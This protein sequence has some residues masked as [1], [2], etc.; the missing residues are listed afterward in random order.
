MGI[1]LDVF[2]VL[3]CFDNLFDVL[4]LES[5]LILGFFKLTRGVNEKNVLGLPVLLED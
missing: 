2:S 4:R 1:F 5:V 3:V